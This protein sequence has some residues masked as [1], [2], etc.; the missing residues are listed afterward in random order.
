M[1][2]TP[3]R[4]DPLEHRR[5]SELWFFGFNRAE[6]DKGRRPSM[7]LSSE[8]GTQAVASQFGYLAKG[9]DASDEAI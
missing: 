9:I 6:G 3:W 8:P 7:Y 2:V 4:P 5:E 1:D